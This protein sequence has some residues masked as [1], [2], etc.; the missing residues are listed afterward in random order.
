MNY[1]PI[2]G[3]EVHVEL[4]TK[5]KMF[6]GCSAEH[7]LVKP[8][9]HTCPVCLGLP[10]ALP[11]PNQ[12]AI[13][14]CQLI[15]LALSCQLNQESKFD[16][17]NYFY[18]DLPKG[19]QISQYDRPLAI[20]GRVGIG[21]SESRYDGI[22]NLRRMSDTRIR[23][24]SFLFDCTQGQDDNRR[25]IIRI[26]RVHLEEDT[27][28]LIHTTVNGKE[29]TLV[30]F[31]RSGVPLVEIVTEPDFRFIEEVD[32]FL[33]KVQQII[34]Y[35]G[36]SDCD[37]EKGS[38]RLEVNMSLAPCHPEADATSTEGS[39]DSAESTL[40]NAEGLD[41]SPSTSLGI[42]NDN[43][44]LPPYKVEIKNINS[45]R[46]VRR[47]IEYEFTRQAELLNQ[48]ITPD[49][50][51]RGFSEKLGK[52]ISQRGKEEAHD[53]RYFP[54]PDI[55]PL[56]FSNRAIE[57]LRHQLPELPDEKEARFSQDYGLN[58]DQIRILI[59]TRQS[60][61]YFEE[62]VKVGQ[63][64]RLKASEIAKVLIN[65]KIDIEKIL[66]AK[67]VEMMLGKVQDRIKDEKFLT[68]IAQKAITDNPQAVTDYRQGKTQAIGALIGQV[69]KLT[70]G[71]A[72]PQVT[73]KLIEK[74]LRS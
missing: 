62:A 3:L 29:V 20:R 43:I 49:Q 7:F 66:P 18:P 34:R 8:N 45:F 58:D 26:N 55:P 27:G 9:T 42:Q 74:Q 1:L 70:Q 69:M 56:V 22:K 32:Q 28:K 17:K 60:A 72:D 44:V 64:H 67:L 30:D 50:E 5:S 40:S 53:Y 23:A 37:M 4:A 41:S 65:K 63:E 11:V 36:V 16:R 12:K 6:C 35:L 39:S 71:K 19:Y 2:I 51:T 48:G 73:Q 46:F 54:E 13:E 33:K 59:Q 31:N 24:R 25:K 21:H 15:G 52:T 38:M 57:Q 68:E 10:G 14:W 61:D 47:A